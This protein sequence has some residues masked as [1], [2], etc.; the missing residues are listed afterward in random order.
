MNR[1]ISVGKIG[2]IYKLIESGGVNIRQTARSLRL[3]RNTVRK[4]L[5]DMGNF[6]SR[7][8]EQP[9]YLGSNISFLQE[10]IS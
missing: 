2:S 3:S 4:Y 10:N 5:K 1:L 6:R 9:N 7:C 8:H